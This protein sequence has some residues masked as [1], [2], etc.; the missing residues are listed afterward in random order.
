MKKL[1]VVIQCLEMLALAVWV[2][3]LITIM[4]TVI[5]AVFNTIGMEAGGRMLTRTFQGYDRLVLI[6]AGVLTLAL[7]A[8]ARLPIGEGARI[9]SDAVLLA[10][11]VG[12]AVLLA[13]YLNPHIVRLQEAAFAAH[14]EA[15][16]RSAYD[17]FFRLHKIARVL[18]LVNLGLGIGAIATKV[19]KWNR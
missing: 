5:P 11:M 9:G 15:A 1:L 3:G 2:G 4:A 8:R 13:W 14:D 18:Y 10:I 16:K 19:L 7:V 17:A 12:I 6:C